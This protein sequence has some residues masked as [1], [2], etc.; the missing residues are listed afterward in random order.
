LG[1]EYFLVINAANALLTICNSIIYMLH[2][3]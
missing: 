2:N 1:E 3:T